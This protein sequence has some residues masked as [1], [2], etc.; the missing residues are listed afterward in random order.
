M[1]IKEKKNGTEIRPVVTFIRKSIFYD[2]IDAV[3]GCRDAVTLKHVQEAGDTS[4]AI[5]SADS[6][7]PLNLS[8]ESSREEALDPK[9]TAAPQKS[10]LERKK[11]QGKRKRKLNDAED[12]DGD[13]HF[14]RAFD[15]E[16][17]SQG[18][19]VASSMEKMQEMQMRQMDCMNQFMGDFLKAFKDK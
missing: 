19:R 9:E 12:G 7:S 1:P 6:D 16:I 18:E 2:E 15:D 11:G 10:R 4:S 3:L 13:E 5:S 14:R 17:K 8:A